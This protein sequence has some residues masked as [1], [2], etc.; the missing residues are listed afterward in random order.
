MTKCLVIGAN[1]QDGSYLCEILLNQGHIVYG[2]GKQESSRYIKSNS[3]F[4]YISCDITNTDELTSIL[5]KNQPSEIYH[6]AAIHG[7]HGFF[8]ED[9]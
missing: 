4:N 1:G 3:N 6:V 7:S 8:Y 9:K 5:K 2:I